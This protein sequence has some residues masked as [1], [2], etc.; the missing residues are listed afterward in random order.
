MYMIVCFDLEGPISPQD[1]AYE[2]M[3]LILNG[4]E[5]FSKISKYDD[6]LA[7]KKK[8]YEAGYTLALILPFLIS[9]KINEDDIKRV[10]EKAKINE[11]VK[12]LVSILKKKH[13]FYIISTSYE[14][15]AYSIGKRIGVPK[16]DI[17]C[18]K[19]PINDYLHY[20]IDLQ[21]AEKEILNLKDHNI[22]EFFNNFY[23]KIDKDIKK[24][25]ENTKVIGGKYK[26]EAIYKILERENENIKS[27][28]AVGDSIT[29][30]KMLKAVKEKGGISIVFN[31]NEYA[32][33]YAEFAFAGTNLLPLAY[34]IES[35]NKKEFIKKWNGEGYFHHVNKD[36]EKIILIHKKYRNIMRGKAG[37]L[38]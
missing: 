12:E 33:P 37:E 15:H 31:G 6:I 18:T 26:T 23:E 21:E 17:Y 5:I 28:V 14:Q 38:G 34:F 24:I 22:E 3:K 16:E 8:D 4:G 36:I 19:F 2:L 25:I 32:I 27:V 7:L 1:N 9:H 13:K 30:F 10:S 20:D 35:K 29:D 11:G